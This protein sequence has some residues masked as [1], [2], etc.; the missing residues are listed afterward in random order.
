MRGSIRAKLLM[1]RRGFILLLAAAAAWLPLAGLYAMGRPIGNF[2]SA[3]GPATESGQAYDEAVRRE[4]LALQARATAREVVQFI[5]D[6][7]TEVEKATQFPAGAGGEPRDDVQR[8]ALRRNVEQLLRQVPEIRE[9][10]FLDAAGKEQL[11]VSRL[12]GEEPSGA[13]LSQDAKFTV[14]LA[15]Q[16][17]LG[18]IYFRHESEPDLTMSFAGAGHDAGVSVVEVSLKPI[19]ELVSQIDVG[20]GQAYV[21]DA[22]GRLIAHTDINLV[23]AKTDMTRLSQVMAARSTRMERVQVGTDIGGRT[24]L[25][26]D[27]KAMPFGWLVFVEAPAARQRE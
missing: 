14:A 6:I 16:V 22:A 25:A 24:V 13:D 17:Y 23:V 18:P 9:V 21:I 8:G 11:H 20:D 12:A 26:G 5:K 4:T 1:K 7:E 3:L 15:K 27:A 10:A 2:L 19:W